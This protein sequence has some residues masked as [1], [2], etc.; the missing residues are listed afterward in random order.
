MESQEDLE[1]RMQEKDFI[2]KKL[3]DSGKDSAHNSEDED[4]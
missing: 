1:K 2:A 3:K 4:E